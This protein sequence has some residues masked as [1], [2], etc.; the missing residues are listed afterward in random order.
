MNSVQK[1]AQGNYLVVGYNVCKIYYING[2]T[3][4]ILWTLGGANSSFRIHDSNDNAFELKNMHHSRILPLSSIDL[5]EY[6]RKEDI[7]ETTH[8]VLSV[9]DNAYD[10]NESPPTA[11]FSSAL[12][13]LLDLRS[14]TARII[15]RYPHPLGATAAMFGSVSPLPNGD[16]FIGWGSA[17]DVSQHTR[18]GRLLYHAEIG[19][20]DALVGSFRAF[21][22]PWIGRPTTRPS[23]YI[24]AWSC[25]WR[26]AVYVSWNGATEVHRYRVFGRSG[27]EERFVPVAE[28]RKDGFETRV[29][30][31]R[32]VEFAFVEALDREG[33]VLGTSEVVRTYRPL[34]IEARGCSV[35]KCPGTLNIPRDEGECGD[36]GLGGTM[37]GER[38]IVLG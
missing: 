2:S 6:V 3:G 5:P 36:D 37:G 24:Y 11:P 27:A 23:V 7:S 15:E 8:L 26:S 20:A 22:A 19:D 12:I 16:R 4:A 14:H 17:R 28:M 30:A 18:D 21:K 31:D 10:A 25:R 34:P 1:D 33:G 29:R 9:F 38:Q 13:L 32:Y 35:W